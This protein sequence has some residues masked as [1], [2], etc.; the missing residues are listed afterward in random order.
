MRLRQMLRSTP[1]NDNSIVGAHILRSVDPY[2]RLRAHQV[3]LQSNY[4]QL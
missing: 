3:E 1:E 4:T 2:K